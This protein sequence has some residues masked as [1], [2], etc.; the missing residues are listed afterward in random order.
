M[1]ETSA[2]ERSLQDYGESFSGALRH[3]SFLAE[4]LSFTSTHAHT[5]VH[6]L[7]HTF[8]ES[9]T[10]IYFMSNL[11]FLY[12]YTVRNAAWFVRDCNTEGFANK[13]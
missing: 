9:L 12:G 5:Y 6:M 7:T 10:Q 3:D 1:K 8:R 13:L 11:D 2:T 4:F